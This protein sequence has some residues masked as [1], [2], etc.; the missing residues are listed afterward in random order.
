VILI[1]HLLCVI[2]QV[3]KQAQRIFGSGFSPAELDNFIPVIHSNIMQCIRALIAACRKFSLAF[4]DTSKEA[5]QLVEA[6]DAVSETRAS[7]FQDYRQLSSAISALWADPA[8]RQAYSRRAEFNLPDCAEYFLECLPK[9]SAADYRP[10]ETDVMRVY[11]RTVGIHELMVQIE[12]NYFQFFDVG[13]FAPPLRFFCSCSHISHFSGTAFAL[14][15]DR[16]FPGRL[17]LF[18]IDS[19]Y[20]EFFVMCLLFRRSTQRAQKVDSHVR[21][22]VVCHLCGVTGRLRPE[23]VRR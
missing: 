14:I 16:P 21:E 11:H 4:A 7:L 15:L 2:E 9:V 12:G 3:F 19:L 22:C 1:P 8:I 23:A 13:Q 10:S 5:V 17:R 20:T 6:V 18:D